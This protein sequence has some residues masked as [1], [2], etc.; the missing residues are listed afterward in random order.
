[1][2]VLVEDSASKYLQF[3]RLRVLFD[4]IKRMVAKPLFHSFAVNLCDSARRLLPAF[5]VQNNVS[6]VKKKVP[7][8]VYFCC[9]ES[10]F[11][12]LA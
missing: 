6:K 10:L 2:V 7:I 4:L 5:F 8:S 9:S 3:V 11:S 12:S 1:M